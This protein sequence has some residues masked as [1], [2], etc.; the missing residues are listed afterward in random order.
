[1]APVTPDRTSNPQ[2]P[3]R[4]PPATGTGVVVR[5]AEESDLAR[6][7]V[8]L[9]HGALPDRPG[10][11]DPS[12]LAPYAAALREI[13]RAGG[14]VLVAVVGEQVVGVCQLLVLQHLQARGGRC[15]ELE[16]VHVHPDYRGTGV[17]TALVRHAVERARALGCYRVQLTSDGGRPDAHR[18]YERQGFTPSH[19]GFKL[20]L[21]TA[22][23]PTTQSPGPGVDPVM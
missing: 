15:A 12:R 11:E 5:A 23:P 6:V 14:E 1:M 10:R 22:E 7:V 17:G 21:A 3:P 20:P 8:L 2:S 9:M 19:V 4:V 13:H 18:F 16:S